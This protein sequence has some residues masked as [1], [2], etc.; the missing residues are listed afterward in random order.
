MVLE[1]AREEFNKLV[2]ILD[3]SVTGDT[4]KKAQTEL[5][6]ILGGNY[7]WGSE[8]FNKRIAELKSKLK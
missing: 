7:K 4:L 3:D 6:Y 8:K 2:T 1:N 5:N